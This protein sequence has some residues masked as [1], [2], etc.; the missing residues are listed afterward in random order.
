MVIDERGSGVDRERNACHRNWRGGREK[1]G[2]PW[3]AL[4][5]SAEHD[6]SAVFPADMAAARS[7]FASE[8]RIVSSTF[9]GAAAS[10]EAS[11]VESIACK[12]T[13]ALMWRTKKNLKTDLSLEEEFYR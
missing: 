13:N 2:K 12:L 10:A 5:L 4:A 9:S 11:R 1:S 8:V 3:A 6:W 7:S